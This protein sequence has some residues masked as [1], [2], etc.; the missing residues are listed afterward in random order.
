MSMIAHIHTDSQVSPACFK[1]W[2]KHPTFLAD[3]REEIF[4]QNKLEE[5]LMMEN[6]VYRR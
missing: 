2:L 1:S 6:P 3:P 4:L 5:N